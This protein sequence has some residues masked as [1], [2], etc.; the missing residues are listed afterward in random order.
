[1]G[2]SMIHASQRSRFVGRAARGRAAS[3]RRLGCRRAG[4]DT[5]R[6]AA[7]LIGESDHCGGRLQVYELS[8][9]ANP[10]SAAY[11]R[12]ITVR[13]WAP[14]AFA[15][16]AEP[17]VV[18]LNDGQ[19]L[20]DGAAS[21]SGD[22][23][24]AARA[25]LSVAGGRLATPAIVGIDHA[26]ADRSLFY[27]P[28]EPGVG[29]LGDP[30]GAPMRPDARGYPGGEAVSYCHRVRH[31]IL[32]FAE[33]R[34]GVAPATRVFGGSSFGGICALVMGMQ[35][36]DAF[37]AIL[38]ESPSLWI[39]RG[40]FLEDVVRHDGAW[41]D[42]VYVGMG[43]REYG[44]DGV[45]DRYLVQ[46]FQR[47]VDGVGLQGLGR[48]RLLAVL[49]QNAAHT[50]KSPSG[51]ATGGTAADP[52]A[53][54]DP[55]FFDE[56]FDAAG[57]VLSHLPKSGSLV[58]AV[59]SETATL[60]AV[61]DSVGEKLAQEVMANYHGFVEGV[62]E[63]SDV[64]SI[65]QVAQVIARNCRR[66][67][68]A[69]EQSV[70][71]DLR[72]SARCV[73]KGRLLDLLRL[74]TDLR[75][76]VELSSEAQ[77]AREAGSYAEAASR[78]A[79]CAAQ[80]SELHG[81]QVASALQEEIEAEAQ[82]VVEDVGASL[83]ALCSRFDAAPYARV[84]QACLAARTD[85]QELGDRVHDAFVR[86]IADRMLSAC[87]AF[88]MA[89]PAGSAGGPT[90]PGP[91]FRV[92]GGQ[93]PVQGGAGPAK[94]A[95]S[96]LE[97]Y[98]EAQEAQA[99]EG[100]RRGS[101]DL[102]TAPSVGSAAE[103]GPPVQALEDL[104]RTLPAERAGECVARC[105]EVG[106]DILLAHHAMLSW[107]DEEDRRLQAREAA[108]RGDADGLA[109][110]LEGWEAAWAG[111]GGAG[112]ATELSRALHGRA[113]AGAVRRRLKDGRRAVWDQFVRRALV[114]LSTATH[115][116]DGSLLQLLQWSHVLVVA[117]ESF[118][119]GEAAALRGHLV[120][121]H[122]RALAGFRAA[123][124]ERLCRAVE[125]DTWQAL[126]RKDDLVGSCDLPGRASLVVASLSHLEPYAVARGYGAGRVPA[127]RAAA[128]KALAAT[129]WAQVRAAR[130]GAGVAMRVLCPRNPFK[131]GELPAAAKD[132]LLEAGSLP[133][134][135]AAEVARH[136]P[137][138]APEDPD[139]AI[140]NDGAQPSDDDAAAGD[141]QEGPE[142]SAE[143]PENGTAASN[144]ADGGAVSA[145]GDGERDSDAFTGSS[146]QALGL[147][148]TYTELVALAMAPRNE[149]LSSLTQAFEV[150]LYCTFRTFGDLGA[151]HESYRGPAALTTRLRL[152]LSRVHG[153]LT[154]M[155]ASI[156]RRPA[157]VVL[158]LHNPLHHPAGA[159][160]S[161]GAARAPAHAP[162]PAS[163]QAPPRTST[164]QAAA[165]AVGVSW[166]K[167]DTAAHPAAS[168][169]G[170]QKSTLTDRWRQWKQSRGW[171]GNRSSKDPAA[172]PH[173]SD[174]GVVTARR[175]SGVQ[176]AREM[177]RRSSLGSA[178]T[179]EQQ[180]APAP[181]PGA[182][183]E[184]GTAP[185]EAAPRA[186]TAASTQDHQQGP[187]LSRPSG[188]G[189]HMG[190]SDTQASTLL[191]SGNL[192]GL[193]ERL[194]ATKVLRSTSAQ[195]RAALPWL[196]R[197]AIQESPG[198]H[199]QLQ[200]LHDALAATGDLSDHML[201]LVA[202]L[203]APLTWL[204]NRI[205]GAAAYA[206]GGAG[207]QSGAALAPAPGGGAAPGPADHSPW[208]DEVLGEVRQFQ[209]L[210]S[211][212]DE[213]AGGA[214]SVLWSGLADS[215]SRAVLDGLALVRRCTIEG[216]ARMG[217]DIQALSAGLAGLAG[218]DHP[219]VAASA[220][221]AAGDYVRGF[222]LPLEEI[223]GW[224]DTRPEFTPGQVVALALL[225]ADATGVKRRRVRELVEA[226]RPSAVDLIP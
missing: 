34:L 204:P 117:G 180:P 166:L 145:E 135:A 222:Y 52:A 203:L 192:A 11:E 131:D 102:A 32:P 95:S 87:R 129:W 62:Q 174:G 53:V 79:L 67:L 42:R 162:P 4:R 202:H 211:V 108:I 57:H 36:P 114:L 218:P 107:H 159:A 56:D 140:A 171:V 71:R 29:D 132:C 68:A 111:D 214:L 74:L 201:R 224:L 220:L 13:V 119:G 175:S 146:M 153:D 141:A 194:V 164:G 157:P 183:S 61:L 66:T 216:R 47:L 190:L 60:G 133:D 161:A 128:A 58:S 2:I 30:A 147:M 205:A 154:S 120:G 100:D 99:P 48:D 41:P 184:G 81:V 155:N 20:F 225:A 178:A 210:L 156:T 105:L 168:T 165:P 37:D 142:R 94:T 112:G 72:V 89:G 196:A 208:V 226:V 209:G 134:S 179:V 54:L 177:E 77:R 213:I 38:V 18:Y 45:L 149:I 85:L 118:L 189:V 63:V 91:A 64:N 55:G 116:R 123:Q 96:A 188:G 44:G 59:D 65:L 206:A 16:T 7:T 173:P 106:F 130:G 6:T 39:A 90:S 151:L 148:G 84:L 14:P 138:P 127:E 191:A 122:S 172:P 80:L 101:A 200:N 223:V 98:R 21:F 104:C 144:V 109:A 43:A 215:L 217:L 115:A 35:H 185:H 17:A 46:T 212:A 70:S 143:S 207:A 169:E 51:Q 15:D 49:E 221:E 1:M 33:T 82:H 5:A 125:A 28:Y 193:N 126:C 31:E 78:A 69:A 50:G 83:Y 10:E 86:A 181:R 3:G 24:E 76:A 110:P 136:T 197:L 160:A 22:S 12:T 137:P 139:R 75:A 19:N 163:G 8:K 103:V 167:R 73:Q 199:S 88:A 182:P 113:L 176:D 40:R 93:D 187:A 23:W 27:C 25:A 219:A 195:V 186:P 92:V 9:S 150:L 198:G 121:I 158:P 124:I 26:G 97:R 170:Q 152:V